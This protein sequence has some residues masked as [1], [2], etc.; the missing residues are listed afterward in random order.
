[1]RVAV[2][3]SFSPQKNRRQKYGTPLVGDAVSFQAACRDIG[4]AL[5]ERGHSLIVGSE[6]DDTAD[7]H[8]ALGG[9]DAVRAQRAAGTTPRAARVMIV[10][11][12]SSG[13]LAF[14]A[15]RRSDP[16]V[17]VEHPVGA[18]SEGAAKL[19]QARLADALILV[20]GGE[21][22][23]LAGLAA[24][25][26]RKPLACIGSFGGAAQALNR[27]FFEAPAYWGFDA[28]ADRLPLLRLQEPWSAAQR[29]TALELAGIEGAPTVMLVHGHSRDRDAL[30]AYLQ[31]IGVPNVIVLADEFAAS[32]PIPVKLER[33]A[34]TAAGAIALLTP[35]DR[36][37]PA[38]ADA[39]AQPRARQNV[40]VEVGWFWGRRGRSRVLLLR[41]GATEVPSD[42][43]NLERYDYADDPTECRDEIAAFIARLRAASEAA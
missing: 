15:E 8:A 4:A 10:R 11:K 36:G 18:G 21:H 2:L 30:K 29:D 40:W 14:G 43:G 1:M 24:A 33:F 41:K 16:D 17:F 27:R 39:T 42:L 19:F 38:Q 13:A 32:E 28:A 20:G 23:E 7:R 5:V 3:G 22:T 12:A 9:L 6:G 37:G 34:A 35:D 26:A 31:S 25:A